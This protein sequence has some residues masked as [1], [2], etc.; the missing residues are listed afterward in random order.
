[1]N[2][3][4]KYVL[5]TPV[6]DEA[7]LIPETIRSVVQQTRLPAEWVIVSD[8]STDGTNDIV[9]A[10]AEQ[11]PWIRLVPLPPRKTRNFAAVVVATETGLRHLEC[12]DYTY[13]GLLDSDV[14]FERSYFE[15]L[16]SFAE[17]HPKLGLTGGVVIDIGQPKDQLPRNLKDIPGA[18]QFFRRQCFADLGGLVA[19]PEGGWD[20]LTCARA[21]MVGYDTALATDL[22]VDHLKPRN[23]AE[24]SVL[25]RHWQLGIR[26]YA[27]GYHPV[28]EAMKCLGRMR[29]SPVLV[30][31][32]GW[33]LGY[34]WAAARRHQRQIPAPLLAYM[35]SEQMQRIRQSLRCLPRKPAGN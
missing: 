32:A 31:A 28:F 16:I 13:V 2:T 35:R 3:A 25:R 30:G 6:K 7:A 11:H 15:R 34:C 18:V 5:I 4:G 12:S 24:G 10:A 17:S 14:R 27:L 21:R 23:I 26:D 20:A 9:A 8:G 22:V 33:W 19:I 1:M 29:S